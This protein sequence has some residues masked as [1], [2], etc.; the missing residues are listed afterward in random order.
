MR[1]AAEGT[2]GCGVTPS[3]RHAYHSLP[4]CWNAEAS[5]SFQLKIPEH[6]HET[7]RGEQLEDGETLRFPSLSLRKAPS[8][9]FPSGSEA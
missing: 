2:Q 8:L 9:H 7:R 3:P 1:P 6:Y 5:Q 4:P